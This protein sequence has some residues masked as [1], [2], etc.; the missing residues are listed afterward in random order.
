RLST[1]PLRDL[2]RALATS[3]WLVYPFA[4]LGAGLGYLQLRA[5]SIPLVLTITPILVGRQAFASYVRVREAND[6]ALRTLVQ[7]L[8]AKDRYTAGHAERVAAYAGYMGEELGLSP[9][10]LE[11]LRRAALMHDIG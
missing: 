6:A 5:G 9:R 1:R 10:A 7:A 2:L 3:Q 4:F 11:P 8:E